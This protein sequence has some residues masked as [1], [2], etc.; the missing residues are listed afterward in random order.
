MDLRRQEVR[1]HDEAVAVE[2]RG[3]FGRD[4]MGE[5]AT[6]PV[7]EPMGEAAPRDMEPGA[8]ESRAADDRIVPERFGPVA[9]AATCSGKAS[10]VFREVI[11]GF[12]KIAALNQ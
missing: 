12:P 1:L 5:T 4:Q 9:T 11:V 7:A 10:H 8:I 2:C 6:A 3:I